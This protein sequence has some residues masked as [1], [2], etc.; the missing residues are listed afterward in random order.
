MSS[1]GRRRARRTRRDQQA[2]RRRPTVDNSAARNESVLAS[3]Q[4]LGAPALARPSFSTR[5]NAP[6]DRPGVEVG[7]ES[8]SASGLLAP[9]PRSQKRA[10]ATR[11]AETPRLMLNAR[12]S[13]RDWFPA[14]VGFGTGEPDGQKSPDQTAAGLRPGWPE[15]HFRSGTSPCM[16]TQTTRICSRSRYCVVMI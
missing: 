12:P 9:D 15:P 7:L 8:P 11:P 6:T 5:Q 1:G 3:S 2:P 16:P 14:S 4:E 13:R 10:M